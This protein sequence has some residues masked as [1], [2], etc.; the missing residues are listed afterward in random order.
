MLTIIRHLARSVAVYS[1]AGPIAAALLLSLSATGCSDSAADS[2]GAQTAASGTAATGAPASSAGAASGMDPAMM[3]TMPEVDPDSGSAPD[4][5]SSATTDPAAMAAAYGAGTGNS[6]SDSSADATTSGSDP[7]MAANYGQAPGS[8]PGSSVA[9]GTSSDPTL[10]ANYGQG[11]GSYPGTSATPG[12]SSD[13]TLA[14]N[15]G[16][17]PGSYPGTS[18]APGTSSDP[19]LAAN[20]G[21]APGAPGVPGGS[22]DPAAAANPASFGQ[23]GV[24]PAGEPGTGAELAG[25]GGGPGGGG[26]AAPPADAPEFPAYHLVMGLMR[27]K[28]EDMASYVSSR[29]RGELQKIAAGKLTDEEKAELKQSFAQPQLAGQPRNARGGRQIVLKSGETMITILVKKEGKDWK[30][31]ELTIRD[32]KKR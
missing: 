11:P 27:G 5:S 26:A 10:A 15:Y 9:T 14:A 21:Q 1:A 19:T 2:S 3:G 12:T 28:Y 16:Q 22:S 4:S 6:G 29:A 30:V 18:A 32:A 7:T 23:P 24:T 13:P 17:A 20:Y 31:A 25:S 8:D